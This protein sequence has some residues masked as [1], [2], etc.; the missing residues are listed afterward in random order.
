MSA[1]S[2]EVFRTNAITSFPL[3]RGGAAYDLDNLRAYCVDCHKEI[4]RRDNS[5]PRP[6]GAALWA[7][8]IKELEHNA[9]AI[10]T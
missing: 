4:T 5:N 10:R 6:P 3:N 9:T 1:M 2:V 7:E 8:Y